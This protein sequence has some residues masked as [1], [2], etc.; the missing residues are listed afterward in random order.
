M[1]AKTRQGVLGYWRSAMEAWR[2]QPAEIQPVEKSPSDYELVVLGTPVWISSISSPLRRYVTSHRTELP[3][4]AFF[5]TEGNSGGEAALS[6]LAELCGKRPTAILILSK[7]DM[8]SEAF[9]DRLA[10]FTSNF[11]KAAT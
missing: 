8:E 11:P 3:R 1:D 4:V 6:E 10:N 7:Q 5:C 9:K 2:K